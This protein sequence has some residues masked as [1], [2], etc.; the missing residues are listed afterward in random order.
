[1]FCPEKK[2]FVMVV[3]NMLGTLLAYYKTEEWEQNCEGKNSRIDVYGFPASKCKK[4]TYQFDK[5]EEC[6][7][8][9]CRIYL[10]SHVKYF[11]KI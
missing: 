5:T 11:A 2:K 10:T 9:T 8:K 3:R 1:M 6:F 4:N 7:Q